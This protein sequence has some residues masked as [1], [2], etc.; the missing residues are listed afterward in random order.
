MIKRDGKALHNNQ[1][2]RPGMVRGG[3]TCRGLDEANNLLM[4]TRD[5]VRQIQPDNVF[6]EKI[7]VKSEG[8]RLEEL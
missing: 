5:I 1:L 3:V 6:S 4:R 2:M 8:F 7:S